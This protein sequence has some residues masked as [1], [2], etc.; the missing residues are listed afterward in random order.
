MVTRYLGDRAGARLAFPSTAPQS[1]T[2]GHPVAPLYSPVRELITSPESAPL[3]LEKL[4]GRAAP[5]EV[6]LGCGDGVFLAA[7]AEQHPERNFLG[8][9]RMLGRLH[10]ACRRAIEKN[11]TN[12]RLLRAENACALRDFLG[13]DSVSVIHLL[14]PDPWPKRRHHRRRL[15]TEDF[16]AM[17]YRALIPQGVLRVATDDPDYFAQ[18]MRLCAAFPQFEPDDAPFATQIPETTFEKKFHHAGSAIHWLVLRKVP[19]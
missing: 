6:D 14:F 18:I 4:F 9:E 11:L 2:C 7:L 17:A 1:T 15:V 8:I 5:L 3:D 12:V 16:L 13:H 19:C 10:G